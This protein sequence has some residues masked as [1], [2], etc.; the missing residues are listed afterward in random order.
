MLIKVGAYGLIRFLVPLFP[1]AAFDFRTIAMVLAVIGIIYG[2][3]MAYAQRDLKRLVAYTSVSH[4]GFVLLGVFAWNTLALQG[5]ILEI[6]CHAFSTGAL[7]LLVGSLQERIHTRDMAKMG[8][9]WTVAPRMGGTALFFALASLG[10]AGA[11]QLRRRV[12]DP[13]GH[14][15]GQPVGRRARRRRTGV[16]HGLRAVDGPARLPRRGDP[17]LVASPTWVSASSACS[18]R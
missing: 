18:A 7:F 3:V 6:V 15:A 16:R 8:G 17:R 11:R 10:P 12:P 9:L 5:A 2:A 1:Q 14:V 4:M 13:A